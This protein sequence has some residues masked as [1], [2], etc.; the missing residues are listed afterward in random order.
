MNTAP[1]S[2]APQAPEPSVSVP[3]KSSVGPIVGALI[4]LVILAAGGLY[5]WGAK[6]NKDR[7]NNAP[8]MILG[9]D[10]AGL[11]PTRS[12]DSMAD[13]EAD[14]AATDMNTFESGVEADMQAV[15]SSL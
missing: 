8:P 5:F 6:L 1:Q 3:E 2:G 13:I 7:A 12:S 15:D 9:D 4:I 14:V 11:P 10:S